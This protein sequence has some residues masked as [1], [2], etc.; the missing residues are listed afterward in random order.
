MQ[1]EMIQD[2]ETT[3]DIF[4]A[5][6]D[7]DSTAETP[8]ENEGEPADQQEEPAEEVQNEAGEETPAEPAPE[9]SFTL[10]Y[11]KEDKQYS[12]DETIELAQ[13]G[14]DYDRIRTE[15]DSMRTELPELR[16]LKGFLEEMAADSKIT[17]EQLMEDVRTKRLIDRE[18]EAG[19]SISDT[20]AREQIQREQAARVKE[21]QPAEEAPVE[22]PQEPDR[23]ALDIAA[24]C[25]AYPDV[26][27]NE[28]PQ[29]V[30]DDVRSGSDLISA[31]TKYE[32]KQLR[33]QIETMK[34][35][36]KNKNRSTGS[37]Q[38]SGGNT[39]KSPFD[40]AWDAADY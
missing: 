8:A 10:R 5:A 27:A 20:A 2:V 17:V 18:R 32:N 21:R 34:Q 19:R 12:R 15:R 14:L 28:I 31:Y 7:D 39:R 40:V 13:K 24:F 25:K 6:W 38:S 3:E 26:K 35:N 22:K 29:A 30:W 16:E 23:A 33:S 11:M 9:E 36:E 37:R 4:E 1:D